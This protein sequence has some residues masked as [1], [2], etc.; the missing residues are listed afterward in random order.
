MCVCPSVCVSVASCCW[1]QRICGPTLCSLS[2]QWQ[3]T[4][5]PQGESAAAS[6]AAAQ[7]SDT[8]Q[9]VKSPRRT[10]IVNLA[11]LIVYGLSQLAERVSRICCV[12]N[13]IS[14]REVGEITSCKA[15]RSF[16]PRSPWNLRWQQTELVTLPG[17][18]YNSQVVSAVHE[19]GFTLG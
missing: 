8:Y 7:V 6:A 12:D 15:A 5:C 11:W 19:C 2:W 16:P 18:F 3:V 13:W 17:S 10:A 1:F 14:C 4:P 9:I